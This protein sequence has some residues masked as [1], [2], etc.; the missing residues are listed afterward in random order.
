MQIYFNKKLKF[1]GSCEK[2]Q[3]NLHISEILCTFVAQI[4]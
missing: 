3:I 1:S 4:G 2:T